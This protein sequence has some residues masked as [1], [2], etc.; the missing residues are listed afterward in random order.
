MK[1]CRLRFVVDE[2]PRFLRDQ[3]EFIEKVNEA[4]KNKLISEDLASDLIIDALR[5]KWD[6]DGATVDMWV[7]CKCRRE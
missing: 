2:L 3:D 1:N 5:A 6:I 7:Y 4:E